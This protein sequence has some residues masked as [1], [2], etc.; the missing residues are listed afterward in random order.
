ML[1]PSLFQLAVKSVA[2]QIHNEQ[3]PLDFH[4]D[5]KSSNAVRSDY[6][7]L[8]TVVAISTGCNDLY[9]PTIDLLNFNSPYSTVKSLEYAL[10]NDQYELA[11]DC[12]NEIMEKLNTIH[13]QLNESEIRALL[14][15]VCCVLGESKDESN[16]HLAIHCFA[17]SSFF[18]TERFFKTF[19]LE[20]P[21][22]VERIFKS[23]EHFKS[24]VKRTAV[25]SILSIFERIVD[26]LRSGRIL[27]DRLLNFIM[28]KT[29]ELSCQYP[30]N[31]QKVT[32]I[33]IEAPRLMSGEQYIAMC[34][35][36]KVIE[37]LFDFAHKLITFHP[38]SYQQIMEI[39]V[40]YLNQSTKNTLNNLVSNFQAVEKCYE[41]VL[42]IS[43]FPSTDSQKNLS[44]IVLR[45]M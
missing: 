39:I 26:F 37:G 4:L 5:T 9:I 41:Q 15:S 10:S 40:R 2:Q 12:L 33:L 24:E 35:N 45:L 14:N 18:Q 19:W 23:W 8:K 20:I 11:E 6:P 38:F 29:V 22:I 25:P 36:K 13:E 17:E 16:K 31:I 30:E 3:I 44:K 1:L 28:E 27:Q 7:K 32:S 34:N 42:I 21:G 43:Q